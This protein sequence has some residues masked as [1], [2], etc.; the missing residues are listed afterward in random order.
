[1]RKIIVKLFSFSICYSFFNIPISIKE[2]EYA[3]NFI[4]IGAITPWTDIIYMRFIENDLAFLVQIN[5]SY[6]YNIHSL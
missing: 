1:M 6:L 4:E 5:R 3:S 2:I